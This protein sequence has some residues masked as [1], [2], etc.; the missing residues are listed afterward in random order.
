MSK[1]GSVTSLARHPGYRAD[2]G[3]IAADRV[4]AARETLRMD[5]EAFATWLTNAVEWEVTAGAVARWEA[6][7]NVPPADILLACN[8]DVPAPGILAGVPHSFAADVLSGAWA[9]SYRFSDPPKYHADIAHV[10]AVSDRRVRITNFPPAPRT[11]GHVFP[12]RNMIEAELASRHLIGSWKN[13]SDARY[14]GAIHL[15]ILPGEMV[16]EGFYTG[17][18]GDSDI[19]II[20]G[21]WRWVRI[22]PGSLE[23]ADLASVTLRDPAE[24]YELVE[25]HS[26]Y[27]APLTL[28]ALGEVA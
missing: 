3:S 27:D 19:R 28:T 25:K 11:Q 15:A 17:L 24:F 10:E 26:Q 7:D 22:E 23:G 1:P 5:R 20:T 18:T 6:G 16:M 13:T 12:Y 2:Y 21:L 14:F 9:T 4:R 8:G